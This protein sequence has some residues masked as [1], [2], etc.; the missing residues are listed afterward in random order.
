M[1]RRIVLVAGDPADLER[2]AGLLIP[3]LLAAGHRVLAFL[4]DTD[5]DAHRLGAGRFDDPVSFPYVPGRVRPLADRRAFEGLAAGLRASEADVAVGYGLKPMWI[6]ALAAQRAEVPR[7]VS[8][9]SSLGDLA[10]H[11]EAKPGPVLGWLLRRAFAASHAVVFHNRDDAVR[12]SAAGLLPPAPSPHVLP[13][14]GVDL[15][16]FPAV[17]LPDL[18]RGIVFT[19]ISPLDRTKGVIDFC[20]AARRI[21]SRGT[22]ARFVLAGSAATGRHAINPAVVQSYAD[23]VEFIRVTHDIRPLLASCHV[24][25]QPSHGEAMPA[26]VLQALATGRPIVA[27]DVPGCRETV[28]E[29]VNGVLVAARD[30]AGLAAGMESIL[31]RP[32]LIPWMSRASRVMAERRFDANAVNAGMMGILGL[33]RA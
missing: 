23:S 1:S 30:P 17:P 33:D 31:K 3:A 26:L 10:A 15:A 16:A 27:T 2:Q 7:I 18:G 22:G 21:R 13:G 8:V 4:P 29:R 14:A 20:E 12:C 9:V 28:D 5:A 6:A 19:M 11:P 32:D 24:C 25:V